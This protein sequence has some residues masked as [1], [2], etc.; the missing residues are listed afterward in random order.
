MI[1]GSYPCCEGPLAIAVPDKTPAYWKENCPNCG[2]VVWHRLSRLD[3]QTWTEAQFLAE[4]TIDE[5]TKQIREINPPPAV[6]LSEADKAAHLKWFE[7]LVLYGNSAIKSP[8]G[9]LP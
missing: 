6:E 5:A 3:P 4:H 1:F 9:L 7:D 8:K 2:A